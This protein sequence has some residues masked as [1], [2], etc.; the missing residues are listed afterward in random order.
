MLDSILVVMFKDRLSPHIRG[1]GYVQILKKFTNMV[2]VTLIADWNQT[3]VRVI[4][5]PIV[6]S[7]HRVG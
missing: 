2:K 3:K 6:S 7:E 1:M 4:I 5:K